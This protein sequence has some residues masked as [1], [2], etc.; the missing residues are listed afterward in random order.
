MTDL[1]GQDIPPVLRQGDLLAG[2]AGLGVEAVYRVIGGVEYVRTVSGYLARADGTGPLI[3]DTPAAGRK[4]PLLE[5]GNPGGI[6]K[7]RQGPIT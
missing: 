6:R 2:R 1:F 4:P 7:C 3:P 5:P